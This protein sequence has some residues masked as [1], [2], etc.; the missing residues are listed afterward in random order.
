MELL[1]KYAPL[2]SWATSYVHF[3]WKLLSFLLISS[4]PK[5][6]TKWTEN[7][8]LL[9]LWKVG[10]FWLLFPSS[11]PLCL[12]PFHVYVTTSPMRL[13]GAALTPVLHIS[14]SE[15][16]RWIF[17]KWVCSKVGTLI[18]SKS[19]DTHLHIKYCYANGISTGFLY[20]NMEVS[21]KMQHRLWQLIF[22][23]GSLI[24]FFNVFS[25]KTLFF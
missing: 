8:K 24:R 5:A 17:L 7:K 3:S 6:W 4:F 10:V 12:L 15:F 23:L 25:S 13:P 19:N 14:S 20:R 16:S 18:L 1:E 21:G 2:L 11:R 22:L 9:H